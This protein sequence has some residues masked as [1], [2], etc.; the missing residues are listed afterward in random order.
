MVKEFGLSIRGYMAIYCWC[1]FGVNDRFGTVH[2]VL[3]L[4]AIG[5][6]QGA[7]DPHLS[8]HVAD[9]ERQEC[10][11]EGDLRSSWGVVMM[12][13]AVW[14]VICNCCCRGLRFRRMHLFYFYRV[15]RLLMY[16]VFRVKVRAHNT[17]DDNSGDNKAEGNLI[18]LPIQILAAPRRHPT[19]HRPSTQCLSRLSDIALPL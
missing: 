13:C 16:G 3:I 4:M 8:H 5:Q 18:S 19:Q 2:C 15:F 9:S 12:V 17:Y 14:T 7:C 1:V 10:Q 6:L 11:G